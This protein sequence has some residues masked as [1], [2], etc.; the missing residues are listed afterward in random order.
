MQVDGQRRW[1]LTLMGLLIAAAW[2]TL[3]I[4][5]HSAYGRY[6]DHGDWTR[7]GVAA[8]I[9]Q[10]LPAGDWLLPAVLYVGGWALMCAAMM[11]P[12]T[13]PLLQIFQRLTRARR[14][15]GTLL[16][17]VIGGY[18]TAWMAFGIVAHAL[19][20]SVHEMAGASTFLTFNG[21]A[22]GAAVVALAG[23]YQL[24]PLKDL[25][26]E[27]CRLPLGSVLRHWN[28]ERPRWRSFRLGLD[29]GVFCVGCCWSLMLLMF[30]VGTGSVAWMLIL[31][32][33]MAAEKNLPWGRRLAPPLGV[34]LVGASALIVSSNLLAWPA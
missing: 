20:W 34:A 5:D 24:L 32:V 9:C 29:H 19:D 3:V 17:L 23:L 26:L 8:A 21:W 10:Q 31:G 18:L 4:W 33:V 11:L 15:R 2:L 12:T 13:L 7:A 28:R 25:C 1:F 30:V 27:R 14:D 6:L 22:I 16:A